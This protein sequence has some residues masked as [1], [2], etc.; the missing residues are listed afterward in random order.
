MEREDNTVTVT[1]TLPAGLTFNS[2]H[3][4]GLDLQRRGPG[5]HLHARADAQRRRL[6][7]GAH[8]HRQRA[9]DGGRERRSTP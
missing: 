8:A 2:A 1:D 3:R 6:V 5:G 4:H 9:R 7:P